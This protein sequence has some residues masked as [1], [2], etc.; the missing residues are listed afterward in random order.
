MSSVTD[1]GGVDGAGETR[2]IVQRGLYFE[3]FENGARY[4]H[5]PG[6]TAT[7]ADN[8]LFSSLTMNTQALHLDA[9]YA[10]SQP[11][12]QRLMNSMWTLATMVGA[13]VTQLTQGTL[14]AQLGSERHRIPRTALPRRHA[15]HRD[16]D[17]REAPIGVTTRPGDRHDAPHRPEP[18]R[19][20]GGHGD[21]RGAHVVRAG[22]RI[23][24]RHGARLMSRFRLGPALLFCPADRPER[25]EKALERADA[26]ILDLE[27]AVA[28]AAKRAARGALIE[29]E[30][31]PSRVIVRVN[32]PGTDDYTADLATLSQTD[33]R[34]IM[35]A[36]SESA[37]RLSKIDRR[38]EVIALCETAKG[39]TQADQHRGAAQRD[40]ADVGRGG[41]RRE[42]RRHV[43]PQAERTLPRHRPHGARPGAPGRGIPGQGGDRHRSS[44]HRRHEATDASRRR[45]PRHP[46][47]PPPRASTRV[48]SR[49]SA[50]PTGPTPRPSP[51]P[52]GCWRPQRAS[53]GSSRTR[54]GW[55][56]APSCAT[57]GVFSPAPSADRVRHPAD[58]LVGHGLG[59]RE[60]D[61]VLLGAVGRDLALQRLVQCAERGRGRCA[62]SSPRNAARS[63]RRA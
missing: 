24:P 22:R 20:G 39:I 49:S 2:G 59:V 29:S 25:Y 26:V 48:R 7:E 31:D 30:L 52:T 23:R 34:R 18:G 54:A 8:V 50:R 15:V 63:V 42:P 58:E 37:K 9:A 38:F 1:A 45:M 28:P 14:V 35:V 53:A 44:R 56:T 13:S 27:D 47:S 32:P 21:T 17:H 40:G 33:Y 4:L 43:E 62:S 5:R 41:S 16:R 57:R 46:A 55:S 10:A 36:K 51:G 6:R 12:G 19:H 3:E 60:D 11:F 61:R